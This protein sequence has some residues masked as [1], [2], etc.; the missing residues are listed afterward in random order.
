MSDM[1]H[2]GVWP[3]GTYIFV[4]IDDRTKFDIIATQV[5]DSSPDPETGGHVLVKTIGESPRVI[6]QHWLIS[7]RPAQK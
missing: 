4:L 7:P 5:S 1:C 2:V 6:F 3:N